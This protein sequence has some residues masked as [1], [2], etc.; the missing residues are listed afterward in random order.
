MPHGSKILAII[1]VVLIF[2]NSGSAA[3][4]AEADEAV[5]VAQ[6]IMTAIIQKEFDAVWD[7]TSDWYKKRVGIQKQ[8]FVANWALSRQIFAPLKSSNIIDVQFTTSD[9][10]GYIGKIYTV[11]FLNEYENGKTYER[12]VLTEEG[13]KF[14]LSNFFGAEAK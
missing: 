13:G 3:R 2:F 7:Q 12:V 11:T 8:A 5:G 10:T 9:P 6:T 4:S 1:A 14:R